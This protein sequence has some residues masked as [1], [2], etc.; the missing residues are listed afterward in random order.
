MTEQQRVSRDGHTPVRCTAHHRRDP[1]Q[2]CNN[3]AV[4][5]ATVCRMHGG[6][7]PG[8]RRKAAERLAEQ[9]ITRRVDKLVAAEDRTPDP[10]NDMHRAM[11]RNQVLCEFLESKIQEI[12]EWRFQSKIGAEQLNSYVSLYER[13]LDRAQKFNLEYL[14]L[15]LDAKRVQ[16][17]EERVSFVVGAFRAALVAAGVG[18]ELETTLRSEFS[19]LLTQGA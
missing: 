15:G 13:A 4:R 2:P 11:I 8:V 5:G 1:K 7:V 17:E 6:S 18:G 3:Y 12:R 9:Q 16:L 14:K 19:R 10:L